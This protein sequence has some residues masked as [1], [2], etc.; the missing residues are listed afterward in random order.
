ML[1]HIHSSA[2]EYC[3][4]EH[5][6]RS[7]RWS[8]SPVV[9]FETFFCPVV[10]VLAPL[11]EILGGLPEPLWLLLA[12]LRCGGIAVIPNRFHFIKIPQTVDC[13]IFICAG[14]ILEFNDSFV[15][16]YIFLFWI[17]DQFE[18]DGSSMYEKLGRG[19]VYP[20]VA[21]SPLLTTIG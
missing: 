1:K 16:C 10:L 3:M 4:M 19:H 6:C 12:L 5:A 8:A 13:G 14:G 20:C 18:I 7:W 2:V 17:L 15:K 21:C 9:V 11:S